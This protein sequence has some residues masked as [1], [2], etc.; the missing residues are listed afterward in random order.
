MPVLVMSGCKTPVPISLP[1]LSLQGEERGQ[2]VAGAPLR[3]PALSSSSSE[4]WN[5]DL[6]GPAPRPRSHSLSSVDTRHLNHHP[7]LHQHSHRKIQF[8]VSDSEDEAGYS[9]DDEGSSTEDNASGSKSLRGGSHDGERPRSRISAPKRPLSRVKDHHLGSSSGHHHSNPPS[10]RGRGY[11]GR[12]RRATASSVLDC[13][14]QRSFTGL[15]QEQGCAKSSQ[16][17]GGQ[18]HCRKDRNSQQQASSSS[19]LEESSGRASSP[20]CHGHASSPQCHGWDGSPKCHGG[21]RHYSRKR[22]HSL[23]SMIRKHS[24]TLTPH[25]LPPRP[26]S[27]RPVVNNHRQTALCPRSSHGLGWDSSA[28]LLTALS[29]E[30][31]ELLEPITEQ[32]YPLRTAILALQKTGPQQVEILGQD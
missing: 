27:V 19:G 16:Y 24:Y 15:K 32:G 20:Q 14:W 1:M 5:S 13:R 25:Q 8:M 3:H 30:E 2:D 22:H 12:N 17:H 9:E 21:Q 26:S 29:Q 6:R 18:R 31:R 10:P 23:C 11:Q 28:E 7:Q 4:G